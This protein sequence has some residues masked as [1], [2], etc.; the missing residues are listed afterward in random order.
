MNMMKMNLGSFTFKDV[1]VGHV[2]IIPNDVYV[3][4]K[5]SN[6]NE[7]TIIGGREDSEYNH[8]YR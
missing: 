7:A 8:I 4:L 5:I 1:R 2:F 6:T 3:Y